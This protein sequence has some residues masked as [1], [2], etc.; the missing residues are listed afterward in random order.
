MGLLS[1]IKSVKAKEREM[2]ILMVY[3]APPHAAPVRAS[4]APSLAAASPAAAA[5]TTR[6]RRR[7]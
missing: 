7:L 2:R 6:A 4:R 5:W 1:V 3:A